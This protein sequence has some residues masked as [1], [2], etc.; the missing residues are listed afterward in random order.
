[1]KK[2]FFYETIML[3]F[4]SLIPLWVLVDTFELV[5][6]VYLLLGIICFLLLLLNLLK[7]KT[8]RYIVILLFL[9]L[10]A[11]FGFI[12][13]DTIILG[14]KSCYNEIVQ[15]YYKSI[16]VSLDQFAVRG[17]LVE[18]EKARFLFLIFVGCLGGVFNHV[19][20]I[21]MRKPLFAFLISLIFCFPFLVIQVPLDW[22]LMAILIAYWFVLMLPIFSKVI[23]HTKPMIVQV[24]MIMMSVILII[25]IF[26]NVLPEVRVKNAYSPDTIQTQ[27][28]EKINAFLQ[29]FASVQIKQS[30]LNL[31]LA[32]N[33]YYDDVVHASITR[34]LPKSLYLKRQSY[35]IYNENKWESLLVE[36]YNRSNIDFDKIFKWITTYEVNSSMLE[37]ISIEDMRVGNSYSLQPYHIRSL[38]SQNYDLSYDIGY[39][40]K[41]S[42]RY[43][44]QVFS[45]Q[46][47][48]RI[49]SEHQKYQSFVK[50]YYLQVDKNIQK[51]FEEMNLLKPDAFKSIVSETERRQEITKYILG[52][53]QDYSYT[54]T[55][56][57]TPNNEDFVTYFLQKSKKG[58]CVHF[59]TAATL[60]FRYYG[61][62]A[63]YV[64]GYYLSQNRLEKENGF[65][66][67]DIL[68]S[69]AH[70]W[71]ETLS[72]L[73][74]WEP[75]EVTVGTVLSDPNDPNTPQIENPTNPNSPQGNNPINRPNTP[76]NTPDPDVNVPQNKISKDRYF[77]FLII[78]LILIY[79][80]I[81]YSIL[82]LRRIRFSKN[83]Q[84]TVYAM[85]K[86]H[87]KIE[88]YAMD[89]NERL[90]ELFEKNRFSEE[91]CTVEEIS[92][93][94][95]NIRKRVTIIDQ[96][97]P[98]MKR[99]YF[100]YVKMYK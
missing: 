85:A 2:E 60:M 5:E 44:I 58:Y 78:G 92:E 52:I 71:V 14:F 80:M 87:K 21:Q 8:G 27:L 48:Y 43:T 10:M 54:L 73:N 16:Q 76:T 90:I 45:G 38:T 62:P 35:A 77:V 24:L 65:Y 15:V 37:I 55:P 33:R 56:G 7:E 25:S 63:R 53:L 81:R 17:S 12:K 30:S 13:I 18:L 41:N 47:A 97:L 61:I 84:K 9:I 39:E 67:G 46:G 23:K 29:H 36:D 32:G 4:G 66:K 1:M 26:T 72:V 91:G 50:E 94:R 99:L 93:I 3:L 51:L 86:Y 22:I 11:V 79:G 34:E 69:D 57:F 64:E 98:F 42:N 49:D 75:V 59:A 74:G 96:N 70:A 6:N 20:L 68:D 31:S 100:R 89:R 19:A 28:I 40:I 83:D 88:K 82:I 95:Q